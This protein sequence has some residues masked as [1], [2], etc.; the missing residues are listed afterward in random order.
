MLGDKQKLQQIASK[1]Q[2]QHQ[3]TQEEKRDIEK[4]MIEFVEKKFADIGINFRN[5]LRNEQIIKN[6]INRQ[7]SEKTKLINRQI[8]NV[9][10]VDI[11]DKTLKNDLLNFLN[12]FPN[13]DGN[14]Q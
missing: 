2:R 11:E 14:K 13:Y 7:I 10:K 8:Q 3:L 9:M 12:N 1:L 4:Q 5:S 6:K